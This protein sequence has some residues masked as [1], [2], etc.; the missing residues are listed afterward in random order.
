MEDKIFGKLTFDHG[1]VK[2]ETISLWGME[3]DVEIRTSSYPNQ[4]PNEKQQTAY[5]TF[6]TRFS[7]IDEVTKVRLA[8]FI[9]KSAEDFKDAGLESILNQLNNHVVPF[10]ILFFQDGS[11]AIECNAD[12]TDEEI[13]VLINGT[14]M[15]VGMSDELLNGKI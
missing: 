12:W 10:E 8:Q 11:Y 9:A 7:E 3:R 1:W 15:T 13:S 14:K 4:V 2:N 6:K 5:K